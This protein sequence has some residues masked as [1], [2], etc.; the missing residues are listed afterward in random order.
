ML[1][2]LFVACAS[3]YGQQVDRVV[4]IV[5]NEVILESKLNAQIQFLALNNKIDPNTPGLK[6]QVLQSMINE[7]LIV[8]KAI[9]DSVTVTD[10]EVQQQLEAAI[11][12][13]VQQVGSEARLETLRH[14]AQQD[15]ARV[16]G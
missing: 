10:D 15:Q 16:P 8:A 5:D 11:Q 7:K 12:Q 6:E 4:A 1:I 13:R 9:E 2:M 14:A 3:A